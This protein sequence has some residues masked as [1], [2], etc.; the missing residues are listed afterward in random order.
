MSALLEDV[1][2][3]LSVNI[4]SD[5]DLNLDKLQKLLDSQKAEQKA[6]DA[7]LNSLTHNSKHTLPNVL[8]QSTKH[9]RD[10]QALLG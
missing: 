7:Q 3:F 10:L 2:S 6:L 9:Q 5:E 4:K 1:D 8:E